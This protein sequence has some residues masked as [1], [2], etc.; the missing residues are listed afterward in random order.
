MR[1]PSPGHRDGAD[2]LVGPSSTIDRRR[3]R[4]SP[5]AETHDR[6][7]LVDA[8][9]VASTS[10]G[11]TPPVSRRSHADEAAARATMD[12]GGGS[13]GGRDHGD[14]PRGSQGRPALAGPAHRL[15][16]E[17]ARDE[18]EGLVRWRLGTPDDGVEHI[19]ATGQ[20]RVDAGPRVLRSEPRTGD[21]VHE[22][23]RMAS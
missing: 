7:D 23:G 6:E 12:P 17:A 2:R 21:Y 15:F 22:G 20:A 18:D 13:E 5:C 19:V 10:F 14:D 9:S 16:G 4:A 8:G 1:S 11:R 3:C